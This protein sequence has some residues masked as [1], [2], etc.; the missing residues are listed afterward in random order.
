[1]A[2]VRKEAVATSI[3][4]DKDLRKQIQPFL[5]LRE[6]SFTVFVEKSLRLYMETNPL[7]PWEKEFLKN[8]KNSTNM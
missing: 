5:S 6:F 4:L 1:M 2:K 8:R 7:T 3:K